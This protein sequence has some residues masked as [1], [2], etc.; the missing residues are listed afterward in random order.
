MLNILTVG[1]AGVRPPSEPRVAP[2]SVSGPSATTTA[3]T[4]PPL[5]TTDHGASRIAGPTATRGGVLSAEAIAHV[6]ETGRMMT[7]R[8]GAV[9][10][11]LTRTTGRFDVVVEGERGIITTFAN[12]SPRSLDR[13]ARNYGW[14]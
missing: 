6:R 10:R 5:A 8:D 12:L 2:A 11:I 14:E 4:E 13:L 1:M 9:V 3:P 7:Q